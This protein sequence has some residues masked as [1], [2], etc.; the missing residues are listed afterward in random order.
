MATTSQVKSGLDAITEIIKD[1]HATIAK[2]QSN[3]SIAVA[4]LNA[5]PTDYADVL[6]TINGYGTVD[7][8]EALSKAELAKLTTEFMALV[9]AGT[10][11]V[12]TDID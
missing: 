5:L 2:A 3:T 9:T 12:N 10:A 8:F 6:A 11:I 1:A 7:A 4:D